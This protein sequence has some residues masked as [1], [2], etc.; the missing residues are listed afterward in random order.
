MLMC[1]IVGLWT[2][3]VNGIY[4]FRYHVSVIYSLPNLPFIFYAMLSESEC[5]LIATCCSAL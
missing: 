4:Y 1:V 2:T 5:M 3:R